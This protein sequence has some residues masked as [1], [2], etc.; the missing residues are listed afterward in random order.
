MDKELY[1]CLSPWTTGNI[2]VFPRQSSNFYLCPPA[3]LY[4]HIYNWNTFACDVKQQIHTYIPITEN[5]LY[6]SMSP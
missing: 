5:L 2:V 3:H 1:I 6:S 4:R